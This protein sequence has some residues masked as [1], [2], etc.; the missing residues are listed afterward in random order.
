MVD[1]V[2]V[3]GV[4]NTYKDDTEIRFYD[5]GGDGGEGKHGRAGEERIASTALGGLHCGARDY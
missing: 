1:G 3:R 2:D 5:T 4:Q